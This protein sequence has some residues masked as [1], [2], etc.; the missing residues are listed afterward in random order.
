MKIATALEFKVLLYLLPS[1]H[2][3][4]ANLKFI[5][6]NVQFLNVVL[7]SLSFAIAP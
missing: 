6:E 2:K 5:S 7:V 4:D 1:S 3:I